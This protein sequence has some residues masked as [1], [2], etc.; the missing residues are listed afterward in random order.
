MAPR[1]KSV[2]AVLAAVGVVSTAACAGDPASNID[3]TIEAGI[4]ATMV[5]VEI[6]KGVEA[7]MAA[8]SSVEHNNR[9]KTYLD[10]GEYENAIREYDKVIQLDP[11]YVD[12]YNG[13]DLAH[14]RLGQHQRAVQDYEPSS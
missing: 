4:A 2:I 12:A 11:N 8:S 13:L 5:V 14:A 7:T 10:L 1:L 3:A 9:A 6:E